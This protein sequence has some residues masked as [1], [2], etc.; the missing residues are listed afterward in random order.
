LLSAKVEPD[1]WATYQLKFSD[2]TKLNSTEFFSKAKFALSG[3]GDTKTLTVKYANADAAEMPADMI[4][5][6][7]REVVFTAHLPGP[8]TDT[9]ATTTEG[10]TVTWKYDMKEFLLAKALE[11]HA[12]Y[13]VAAGTGSEA[14]KAAAPAA[15]GGTPAAQ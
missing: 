9:N 14:P 3:E 15:E 5:Y 6:F 10:N 7:G 4:A 12:T 1:K 13:K 2:V 8:V 11:F